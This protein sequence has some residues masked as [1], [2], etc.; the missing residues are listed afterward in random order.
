M[1]KKKVGAKPGAKPQGWHWHRFLLGLRPD[2]YD[3]LMQLTCARPDVSMAEW[4]RRAI[5]E[6]YDLSAEPPARKG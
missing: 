2:E 1:K 3:M 5:R 6:Q 4:V